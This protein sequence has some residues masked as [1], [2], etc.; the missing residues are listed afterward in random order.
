[1]KKAVI[2]GNQKAGLVDVPDPIPKDDWVV[3]KVHATAMC[4]EY[5][6]FVNGGKME[7]G[8]HEGAGEVVAM[9]Q[10]AS[11]MQV[12]DR[13]AILPQTSCG[14]CD[15]CLSGDWIYCENSI[16]YKAFIGTKDGADTFA[17]FIVKPSWLL[18]K[19]PDSVSYEHATM[20]TDGVG[21]P[22]GALQAIGLSSFDTLLVT[23]LGPVGLGGVL[24]A[25][26]RGAR[27]IGVEPL[28]WR[29]DRAKQLGA[30]LVFD[31]NEKDLLAKIR[32]H[33]GGRGVDCAMDCSGTV[34][35]ERLCIDATR[36][37]GRV[38]FVGESGNDLTIQASPDLI[39]KGL[40]LVGNWCWRMDDFP[41]IMRVIQESPSIDLLISHVMPM[42]SIQEAFEL[43][44][45]GECAKV[46]LKPWE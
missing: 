42:S 21:T 31:P 41:H 6:T 26:F 23:G 16:D 22:Y 14:Q 32:E 19:I 1:M 25:S 30:D 38:V 13:V 20:V 15:L 9:A 18:K 2:F 29:R 17:H 10:P 45:T 44:A 34:Q 7:N 27:T 36:R 35:G 40:T 39:H 11:G 5:K 8:G 43:L 4:T 28:P 37:R 46:V 3:V 24:N 33:T 12:G